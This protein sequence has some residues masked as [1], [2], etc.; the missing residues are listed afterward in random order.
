MVELNIT[1]RSLT[2]DD[3]RAL[4]E[5]NKLLSAQNTVERQELSAKEIEMFLKAD[6]DAGLTGMAFEDEDRNLVGIALVVS[7]PA[8][9]K[10]WFEDTFNADDTLY[11][12]AIV[13]SEGAQRKGV[14]KE[15]MKKVYN[16]ARVLG[17]TQILLDVNNRNKRAYEWYK[18]E[19]FEELA[20]QV[21]M[22]RR[23]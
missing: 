7:D 4:T 21:Y 16:M 11:L 13:V 5:F 20:S 14:G 6:E 19:G 18:R 3:E 22:I 15:I 23:L 17:K 8:R 9:L 10:E 1:M 12:Y 2:S